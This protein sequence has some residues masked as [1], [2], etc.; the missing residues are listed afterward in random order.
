M[1]KDPILYFGKDT[2]ERL[3]VPASKF[4]GIDPASATQL[5]VSFKDTDATADGAVV[6]L[7]IDSG[8]TIKEAC[9]VLAGALY[10]QTRGLTIVAG[11]E[12]KSFLYPFISVASITSA[13]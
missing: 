13:L 9:E 4:L 11:T 7:N 12:E 8:S 1:K 5:E 10:G 6:V 2:D 3:A